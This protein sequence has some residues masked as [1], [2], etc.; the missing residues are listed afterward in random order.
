MIIP[1]FGNEFFVV[2]RLTTLKIVAAAQKSFKM[3]GGCISLFPLV[4]SI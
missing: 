3:R 4:R 1:V 2:K